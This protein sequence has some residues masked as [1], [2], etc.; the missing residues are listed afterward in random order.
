MNILIRTKTFVFNFLGTTECIGYQL[1]CPSIVI[2]LF[3]SL[4]K[5]VC[6][7]TFGCY[8]PQDLESSAVQIY[9]SFFVL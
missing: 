9:V 3:I 5:H 4:I 8:Y 6:I 1:Q 2:S 7:I